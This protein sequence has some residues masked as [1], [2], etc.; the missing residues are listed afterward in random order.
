MMSRQCQ[1]VQFNVFLAFINKPQ[2]WVVQQGQ[3]LLWTVF[4]EMH[5]KSEAVLYGMSLSPNV[6][7]VHVI[8]CGG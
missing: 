1:I 5:S 2:K 4:G 6:D 8:D 3:L 7:K